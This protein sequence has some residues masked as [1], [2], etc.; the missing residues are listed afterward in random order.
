MRCIAYLHIEVH[1]SLIGQLIVADSWCCK[2]LVDHMAR[3]ITYRAHPQPLCSL[4]Q[5]H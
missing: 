3:I 4:P 1:C 2:M 5:V